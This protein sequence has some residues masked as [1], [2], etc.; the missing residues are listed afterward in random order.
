MLLISHVIIALFSIVFTGVSYLRPS[1]Q[2]VKLSYGL[3]GLTL[4]S[5][6]ALV[7]TTHSPLLA[8]CMSGLAYLSI[9]LTGIVLTHRK[10]AADQNN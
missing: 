3:V 2:K 5:G 1:Q 10:L 4:A 6:T 8:S 7:I 9:V